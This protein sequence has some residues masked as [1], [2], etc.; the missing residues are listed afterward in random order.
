MGIS[1]LPLNAGVDANRGDERG[2]DRELVVLAK[3]N[4]GAFGAL[5]SRYAP[6]VYWYAFHRLGDREAAEDATSRTFERA[7]TALG[8]CREDRFRAWLFTLARNVVT[9]A[10]RDRRISASLDEATTLVAGGPMPLDTVQAAESHRRV[11]A[12]LSRLPD[13]QRQIVELRLAGLTGAEIARVLGRTH[14][15]V[16]V[17]QLRAYQRLRQILET[18]PEAL[19]GT[20]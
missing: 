2:D 8:S 5:Y 6:R 4:P 12:L 18:E 9:D 15:A 13:G 19:D 11:H 7:L 1:A 16:R 14:V 20:A 3:A 17:S 10:L